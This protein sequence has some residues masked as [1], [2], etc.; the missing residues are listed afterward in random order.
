[1]TFPDGSI[2]EG[3]FEN[4]IFVGAINNDNTPLRVIFE[5]HDKRSSGYLQ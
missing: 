2:K 1:M 3:Q 5:G 4:N